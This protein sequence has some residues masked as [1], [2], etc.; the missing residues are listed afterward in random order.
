MIQYYLC[1]DT[2]ECS[3]SNGG[4]DSSVN[5]DCENTDGSYKCTCNTGYQ[6]GTDQHTCIGMSLLGAY[7]IICVVYMLYTF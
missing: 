6:L 3:V 2:D 5:G 1:A 4:C 7:L